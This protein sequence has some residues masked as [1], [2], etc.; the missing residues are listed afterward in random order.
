MSR[1]NWARIGG[2]ASGDSF[3][4]CMRVMEVCRLSGGF[5]VQF[6]NRKTIQPGEPTVWKG[7]NR[8]RQ[9]YMTKHAI[10][11]LCQHAAVQYYPHHC[12]PL[13]CRRGTCLCHQ[14]DSYRRAFYEKVVGLSNLWREQTIPDMLGLPTILSRFRKDLKC[15]SRRHATQT[16]CPRTFSARHLASRAVPKNPLPI[17][18]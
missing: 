8:E 1:N 17:R 10:Q 4:V 13:L 14:I 9:K 11:R 2:L 6:T 15:S 7:R 12:T 3:C 16:Y 5:G 18:E